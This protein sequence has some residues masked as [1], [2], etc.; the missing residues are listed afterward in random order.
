M[1]NLK[2][3]ALLEKLKSYDKEVM[4]NKELLD[5]NKERI[6]V[7]NKQIRKVHKDIYKSILLFMA[8]ISSISILTY[9]GY[10]INN[11]II[12]NEEASQID[13][14]INDINKSDDLINIIRLISLL[15]IML[16]NDLIVESIFYK[17]GLNKKEYLGFISAIL[18]IKEDLKEI[19]T[20]SKDN[21]DIKEESKKVLIKTR[22]LI[23]EYY[24]VIKKLED[25]N[26][27]IKAKKWN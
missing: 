17:V 8:S 3:L 12:E 11:I 6:K 7:N 23:T 10:T 19:E 18:S 22:Q 5:K 14:V 13:K 2:K 16:A 9:G 20:L 26:V 21:K 1:N 27:L 4:D 24:T 15:T 25:Q